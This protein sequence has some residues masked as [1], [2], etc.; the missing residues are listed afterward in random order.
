MDVYGTWL[1]D[2]LR[3]PRVVIN[4]FLF[5][6]FLFQGD[7]LRTAELPSLCNVV[8]SIYQLFVPHF[9]MAVFMCIYLY[10]C[11]NKQCNTS[12]EFSS[13]L[14]TVDLNLVPRSLVDEAEG[15]IWPNPICIT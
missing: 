5:F 15:E 10:Y 4:F 12:F 13:I 2:Q 7:L 1:G 14:L 8:S 3:I 11:V 6:S 9:A